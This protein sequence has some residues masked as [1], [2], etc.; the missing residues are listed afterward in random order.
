MKGRETNRYE[1]I[2]KIP[3]STNQHLQTT[4]IQI[5]TNKQTI[6]GHHISCALDIKENTIFNESPFLSPNKN[7]NKYHTVGTVPKSNRKMVE[8][9]KID[10]P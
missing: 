4:T 3:Q 9:G 8:S 7:E 6:K 10:T 1:W 5:P 2:I